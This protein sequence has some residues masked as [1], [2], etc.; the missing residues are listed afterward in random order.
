MSHPDPSASP[1]LRQIEPGEINGGGGGGKGELT[2]V[3][4]GQLSLCLHAGESAQIEP[5]VWHDWFNTAEVDA[6]V[7][8]EVTPR[9]RF[10]HMIETLSGLAREGHVNRKGIPNLL[11]LALTAQEF[12]DV[13]VFRKPSPSV[14]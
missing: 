14:Q 5:W 4:D 7:R 3:C 12:S 10:A 6:V 8:V 2:V 13:I 11:Q 1:D 9:E